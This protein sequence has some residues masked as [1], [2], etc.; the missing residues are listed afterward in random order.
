M[1]VIMKLA[2]YLFLFLLSVLV[3]FSTI[4]IVRNLLRI[5][6]AK[7]GKPLNFKNTVDLMR[8]VRLYFDCKKQ[9]YVALYGFVEDSIYDDASARMGFDK[10]P[11][12]SVD[13]YLISST[14]Y[15]K[16][17]AICANPDA[18]LKKGDFVA[19]LPIYH[20]K[21]N[22]WTYTLATKLKP[23]FLGGNNGFLIDEQYLDIN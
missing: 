23:I 16:L 22:I 7:S 15:E 4:F 18:N 11:H 1:G 9:S 10:E 2:L 5:R 20:E 13:V 12:L 14:G 6:A 19:V 17:T 3:I 21:H 8:F